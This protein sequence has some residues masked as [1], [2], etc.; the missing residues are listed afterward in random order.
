MVK[1]STQQGAPALSPLRLP[2]HPTP[3]QAVD[4]GVC[5]CHL[6]NDHSGRSVGSDVLLQAVTSVSICLPAALGL[7]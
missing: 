7:P 1:K 6:G 4:F 5:G 2:H 3:S